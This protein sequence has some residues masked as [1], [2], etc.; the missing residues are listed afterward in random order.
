MEP[1]ASI[2]PYLSSARPQTMAISSTSRANYP[3]WLVPL[4][5]KVIA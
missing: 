3:S 4:C 1:D 5:D 2:D